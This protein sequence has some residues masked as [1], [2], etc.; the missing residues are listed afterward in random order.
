M[1]QIFIN[2]GHTRAVIVITIISVLLVLI[3]TFVIELFLFPTSMVRGMIVA[4]CV[5]LIVAPIMGWYFVDILMRVRQLEEEM[6]AMATYDDLTGLLRRREFLEQSE[7]FRKIAKRNGLEFCVII[8]D[9]DN[10]K[11]INDEY[12]HTTGDTLLVSFC[13]AVR[14]NFRE[15]DLVSRFGGD[16]F[17]FF[18]ADTSLE[19]A[20]KFTE[21]LHASLRE[22]IQK[23]GLPIYTTMSIGL[24]TNTE[25]KTENIEDAINAADKALY[26]A[27]NNG[28]NQTQIYSTAIDR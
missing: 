19:Q 7:Y 25:V 11:K 20:L 8:V 5:T 13:K 18:L 15:S 21:R 1:K 10:F 26:R 4:A 17:V 14:A 2:L 27:K 24:V 16:E 6:R 9:M 23:N 3:V 28:G 12:G 22:A